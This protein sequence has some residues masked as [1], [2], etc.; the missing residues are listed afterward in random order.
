[1]LLF[2]RGVSMLGRT[3]ESC[4]YRCQPARGTLPVMTVCSPETP[5][6]AGMGKCVW[7]YLHVHKSKGTC[8]QKKRMFPVRTQTQCILVSHTC[9]ITQC[10]QKKMG[11]QRSG[12]KQTR[13]ICFALPQILNLYFPK[14]SPQFHLLCSLRFFLLILSYSVN[15]ISIFL[16]ELKN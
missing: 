11:L 7:K 2:Y 13:C 8:T 3:L 14:P 15:S 4:R 6:V 5:F 10:M 12:R 9:I 1:M 16:H